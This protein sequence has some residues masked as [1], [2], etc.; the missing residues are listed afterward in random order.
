MDARAG[1]QRPDHVV[2]VAGLDAQEGLRLGERKR[3]DRRGC[4]QK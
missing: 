1:D 3:L 4:Q 2:V